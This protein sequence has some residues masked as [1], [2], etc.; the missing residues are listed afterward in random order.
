MI[1]AST[2]TMATTLAQLKRLEQQIQLSLNRAGMKEPDEPRSGVRP[3]GDGSPE[4]E[5]Q[6][7]V[8]DAGD[9]LR[10]HIIDLDA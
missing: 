4:T 6:K 10:G 5:A 2:R 3:H 1:S 8:Q 9:L 7:V